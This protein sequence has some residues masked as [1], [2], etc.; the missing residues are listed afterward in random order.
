MLGADQGT[1]HA[2]QA[3]A[4]VRSAAQERQEHRVGAV[5][6]RPQLHGR[7][8]A[9]VGHAGQQRPG[10]ELLEAGVPAQRVGDRDDRLGQVRR[11]GDVG[12]H[13]AGAQRRDRGVEQLALQPGQPGQVAGAAPARL[14]PAA[15]R[16]E[17]AAGSVEQHPVGGAV[18]HRQARG[19]RR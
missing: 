11:A 2:G 16:A 18:G 19:R 1:G 12:Q 7:A 4:G 3:T 15:Q 5:P 13:P 14:R 8:V 6:V 10:V 9:E 17:A